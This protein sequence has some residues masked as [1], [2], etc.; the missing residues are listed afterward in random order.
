MMRRRHHK[1]SRFTFYLLGCVFVSAAFG[2][3]SAKV[4]QAKYDALKARVQGG[5][6][7]IDW[8][9]IRL[10][11]VV[12]DVDGEFDWHQANTAGVAAFNAGDYEGALHKGLEI[13]QHNLA[14]GDGHFLA[15]VSLKHL[16]KQEETAREK[17]IVDQILQ[18]ILR[19]G[20]G[21]TADTAWFTVSTSEEYF[22][23][24]LLGLRPKSQSLVKSGAHSF[25]LMTVAGEDGKEATLWFN[26]D[27]DIELTRRAGES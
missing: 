22:V 4:A 26:T 24:R 12:A 1:L 5:D 15:M 16:G 9:D 21:K 19:S 11:A 20:D 8:R 10:D 2:L 18:S 7:N 13:I 23:I 25:D 17:L 27:T 3:D 14:N 6:I